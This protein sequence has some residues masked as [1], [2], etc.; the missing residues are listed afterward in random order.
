M[1]KKRIFVARKIKRMKKV[2]TF[3]MIL[4]CMT[5]MAQTRL[6]SIAGVLKDAPVQEKV[7]LHL[8]N[9]CYYKGDTIWY[10]SYVVRADN[11]DYT[12]MS[13]IVYVELV[14]PDGLVVERQSLIVSPDGHW[15]WEL[16]LAR[17]ALFRLLRATW[18]TPA[19]C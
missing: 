9:T 15:R 6:D 8:D 10:K 5:A 18:P 14:S 17:L 4:V 19:G 7:Y 2:V 1:S 16:R 13:R 11:L 12:D 3:L